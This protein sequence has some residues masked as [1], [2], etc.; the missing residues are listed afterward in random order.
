MCHNVVGVV[1]SWEVLW[2]PS[3]PAG[4]DFRYSRERRRIYAVHNRKNR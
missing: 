3:R 1:G 2:H 4:N